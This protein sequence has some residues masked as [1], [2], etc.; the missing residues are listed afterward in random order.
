[1][2][3]ANKA[4]AVVETARKGKNYLLGYPGLIL[5]TVMLII[6]VLLKW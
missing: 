1:M 3:W 6:A 5:A 2:K 4:Q